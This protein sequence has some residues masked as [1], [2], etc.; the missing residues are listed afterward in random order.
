MTG[1]SGPQRKPILRNCLIT[2]LNV[3]RPVG[4]VAAPHRLWRRTGRDEL[5]H[6][7][8]VHR[9]RVERLGRRRCRRLRQRR[10][11]RNRILPQR[12]RRPRVADRRLRQAGPPGWAAALLLEGRWRRRQGVLRILNHL[13][14]AT[15]AR[16]RRRR[17]HAAQGAVRSR[18]RERRRRRHVD[19]LAR[20]RASTR[21]DRQ[22]GL[23]V[24]RLLL[25]CKS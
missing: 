7:L 17:R 10:R 5:R 2:M 20:D 11:R 22:R 16:E 12:R 14:H 25:L 24:E 18:G 8:R 21:R 15:R 13:R 19:W 3:I 9:R 4:L 23:P 1:G 6:I